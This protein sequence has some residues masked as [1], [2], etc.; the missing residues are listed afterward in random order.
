MIRTVRTSP[1]FGTQVGTIFTDAAFRAYFTAFRAGVAFAAL[2]DLGAV[3][4]D[5]AV[6]AHAVRFRFADTAFGAMPA[7]IY[8]TIRTHSAVRTPVPYTV[9]AKTAVGT[10]IPAV[11]ANAAVRTGT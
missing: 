9:A 10:N 11:R 5:A 3:R 6:Y 4:A 1:A 2:T 8:G 7:P